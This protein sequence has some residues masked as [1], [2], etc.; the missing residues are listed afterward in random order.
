MQSLESCFY[1]ISLNRY[2]H[3]LVNCSSSIESA[4][5]AKFAEKEEL[6]KLIKRAMALMPGL[7]DDEDLRTLR[8]T[9]NNI[10]H[11]G[12]S[13]KDDEHTAR[14]LLQIGIPFLNKCYEVFFNFTLESG[15]LP[16][17]SGQLKIASDVYAMAKN[18][19][20]QSVEY[21]FR[22]LGHMIRRG[23]KDSVQSEAEFAVARV[24]GAPKRSYRAMNTSTNKEGEHLLIGFIAFGQSRKLP[25][26]NGASCDT[27]FGLGP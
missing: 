20:G 16:E 2:P 11:F 23:M 18:V 1:L 4:L 24:A 26:Q 27:P 5:K 21:C 15:L 9:R 13:P 19:K 7:F 14:L 25:K 10:V 17:V 12:F 22:A 8:Q 6:Y 3:A